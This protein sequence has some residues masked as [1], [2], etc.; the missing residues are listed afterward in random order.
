MLRRLVRKP[1]SRAIARAELNDHRRSD[2]Q[3]YRANR[4]GPIGRRQDPLTVSPVHFS[5]AALAPTRTH[6]V[7]S[8]PR[9]LKVFTSHGSD[10]D[11]SSSAP[12]RRKSVLSSAESLTGPEDHHTRKPFLSFD[13][14]DRRPNAS[15]EAHA[16]ARNT[17]TLAVLAEALPRSIVGRGDELGIRAKSPLSLHPNRLP[18]LRAK[19]FCLVRRSTQVSA[20]ITEHARFI[21]TRVR[22]ARKGENQR[23]RVGVGSKPA[24]RREPESTTWK[25][26]WV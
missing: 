13:E 23:S 22:A 14:G 3:I 25:P 5:I 17:R 24:W 6:V 8:L 19:T 2:G 11:T 12:Q 21:V 18:A 9:D 15:Y 1:P 10:G 7:R 16:T 20:A 26:M 4:H